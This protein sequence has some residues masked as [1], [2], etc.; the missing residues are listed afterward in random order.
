MSWLRVDD[1]YDT[2]PK[3]LELT[4][5]QRWRWTRVLIH[6]ARHRTDG[7]VSVSV[8]R[9][10]GLGRSITQL[11]RVNLLHENGNDGYVVHDWRIYNADTIN[12]KVAAYLQEH[13]DATANDV[14]RSVGGKREIVLAEVAVIRGTEPVPDRYPSGT[15]EPP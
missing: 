10:L 15:R 7:H 3:L 2:H 8:L 1:G 6:C 13:P 9:E 5:Q 11:V 12:G 14:C 4:E